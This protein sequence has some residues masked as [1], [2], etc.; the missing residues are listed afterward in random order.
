MIPQP[1]S[2]PSLVP[3]QAPVQVQ[4]GQ[5][6]VQAP[7][8]GHVQP[9]EQT[10]DCVPQASHACVHGSP[11]AQTPSPA[12]AP[13]ALQLQSAWQVRDCVPQLPQATV[14]TCPGVQ[15]LCPEQAPHGPQVQSA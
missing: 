2:H 10:C 9:I 7:K 5:P 12:Q 14:S 8:P 3:Y 11:G 13:Y 1:Q 4:P 15:A 6:P